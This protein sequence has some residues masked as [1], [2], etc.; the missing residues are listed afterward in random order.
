LHTETDQSGSGKNSGVNAPLFDFAESCR[1]IA[2]ELDDL[3]IRPASQQLCAPPE[4]RCA[5]ARSRR[6]IVQSLGAG[7]PIHH[8]NVARIFA[9]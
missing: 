2:A 9:L 3:E 6:Q 1:N 5:D 8:E 7:L 4:T